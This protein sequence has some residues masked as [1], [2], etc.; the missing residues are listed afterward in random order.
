MAK[1]DRLIIGAMSGT[2]ADG[3][4]VAIV[5]VTGRGLEMKAELLRHLHRDYAPE[6]KAAIFAMRGEGGEGAVKLPDL[7]RIG[8]EISLCYAAAVNEALNAGGLS[9]QQIDA[10]AA[11]GQT[12][13]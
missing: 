3:V 1:R 6:L 11:H 10:V 9:A 13:Y 4:D 5:R 12:L 2:S 8:R 7:A